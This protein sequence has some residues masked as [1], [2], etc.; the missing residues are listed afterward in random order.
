M[1][2]MLT[3]TTLTVDAYE[4]VI[5]ISEQDA[6]IKLLKPRRIGCARP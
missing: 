6:A 4:V 1:M 2:L 5:N 3:A